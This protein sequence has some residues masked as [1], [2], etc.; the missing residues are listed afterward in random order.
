MKNSS[1]KESLD[2]ESVSL[3]EK[4]KF[5][6]SAYISTSLFK[7]RKKSRL[8]E[9]KHASKITEKQD[10]ISNGEGKMFFLEILLEFFLFLLFNITSD[11]LS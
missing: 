11:R 2:K 4:G 5:I 9:D 7:K 1:I 6:P 10:A 3:D 8:T